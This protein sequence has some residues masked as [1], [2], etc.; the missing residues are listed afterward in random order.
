MDKEQRVVFFW[1]GDGANWYCL[2]L[3]EEKY[4]KN[5]FC[6]EDQ[7]LN[8]ID[9]L[10]FYNIHKYFENEIFLNEWNQATK[11]EYQNKVKMRLKESYKFFSGINENNILLHLESLEKGYEYQ[12]K[13]DF[14]TLITDQKIYEKINT[15]LLLK[16]LEKYSH[17]IAFIL[18]NERLVSH[19]NQTI[20]QFLLRYQEAW[21]LYIKYLDWEEHNLYFPDSLTNEQKES[22]ILNY[23]ENSPNSKL[24]EFEY[25]LNLKRISPKVK[26][27]AK[28][29]YQKEIQKLFKENTIQY[30]FQ[31]QLSDNQEV[32]I[33][34]SV[35]DGSITSISYSKKYFDT[36]DFI[37]KPL[38]IFYD[39]FEYINIQGLITL[40][41]RENEISQ[42]EEIFSHWN[43]WDYKTSMRFKMKEMLSFPQLQLLEWYLKE[44]GLSLE[45]IINNFIKN[46][47]QK[48]PGF[49]SLDFEISKEKIS[50]SDRTT[51]LIP[52]LEKLIKQYN[53]FVTEKKIDFDLINMGEYS[54]PYSDIPSLLEHKYFYILDDKLKQLMCYF[55]SDQSWLF[56]IESVENTYK[57][58][59]ELIK[60][61]SLKITDFHEYQTIVL[62]KMI[63][64]D[65]LYIDE[66]GSI[67]IKD[68]ILVFILWEFYQQEVVSYYVYSDEIQK[69]ILDLE[70][71]GCLISKK[72]LLSE[73]ESNYF[74]YYLNK[75]KFI[76][77]PDIR[78]KI[79]W[80]N[81]SGEDEEYEDYLIFLKLI[82]LLLLK[83]EWEL[84][85]FSKVG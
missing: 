3:A 22:I 44:K 4:L 13:K 40:V 66:M 31:V 18:E 39:V 2:K 11:E 37:N 79:H 85:I 6:L 83:I 16:I 15:E 42:F 82:I 46:V 59:Y 52:R 36:I 78:N 8:I 56:Y 54:I 74:D 73:A 1:V 67:R 68:S 47:L 17:H 28:E 53:C 21:G 38:T 65:V 33:E 30:W 14:W 77:W 10:E 72:T 71:Q 9:Y 48:I 61:E 34:D 27:K 20:T 26:L 63:E 75:K 58:F 70:Q 35:K 23:F 81:Y 45:D 25:I 69:R 64:D 55:Y 43:K 7:D 49:D 19:F 60:K 32:I 76:N 5:N 57:N 51:L 29:L 62:Q 41:S 84:E 12:Y 80:H 50:F 24:W